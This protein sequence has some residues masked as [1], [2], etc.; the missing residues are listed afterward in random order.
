MTTLFQVEPTVEERV[1]LGMK[2]ATTS[3]ASTE[4]RLCER[5]HALEAS[6]PSFL[7]PPGYLKHL[8]AAVPCHQMHRT[9]AMLALPPLQASIT[10]YNCTI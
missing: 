2:S 7:M 1:V 5:L 6:G 8:V 9:P 3:A 4:S 10:F